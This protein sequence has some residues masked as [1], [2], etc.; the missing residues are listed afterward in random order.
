[1]TEY[2][3]AIATVELDDNRILATRWTFP[4]NSA[5]GWHR[6]NHDYVVVPTIGGTLTLVD[7]DGNLTENRIELGKPYSR[8]LGVEHDVIN[9]TDRVIEF[10]EIEFK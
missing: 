3:Q 9:R 2:S 10:V 6:H 7:K 5:T 4:P 1:M 8:S